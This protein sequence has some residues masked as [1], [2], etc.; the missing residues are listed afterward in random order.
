MVRWS[1]TPPT[2]APSIVID[3]FVGSTPSFGE[4]ECDDVW[5]LA[6]VSFR[7]TSI[8]VAVVFWS[9]IGLAMSTEG[10]V[11]TVDAGAAALNATYRSR[12]TFGVPSAFL[13]LVMRVK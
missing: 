13:A 10:P 4:A 2:G 1:T 5:A 9:P 3:S 11:L 12:R 6:S 8:G 7:Y